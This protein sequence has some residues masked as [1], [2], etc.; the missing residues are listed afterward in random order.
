M[1]ILIA[2][3]QIIFEIIGVE[4]KVSVHVKGEGDKNSQVS[5]V[6]GRNPNFVYRIVRADLP[7]II[8]LQV[9]C[10]FMCLHAV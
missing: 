5:G 8:N 4:K 3:E 9:W 6:V 2:F 10:A 1:Y 7:I